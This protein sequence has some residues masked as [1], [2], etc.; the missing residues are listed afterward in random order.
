MPQQRRSQ[1]TFDE[2]Q[3]LRGVVLALAIV[4]S[5]AFFMLEKPYYPWF[6]VVAG[7]LGSIAI[8]TGNNLQSLGM[9][10]LE[11]EL[12]EEQLKEGVDEELHLIKPGE[13]PE[14]NPKDSTLWIIGTT[15]FVSG[16]LLNFASYSLA[17]Q[18]LLAR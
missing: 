17:P 11:V 14:I 16:S 8:N 2:S 13:H 5:N 9:Q 4:E 3:T 6:G 1:K 18:S 10:Q 12:L 7:L 15:V